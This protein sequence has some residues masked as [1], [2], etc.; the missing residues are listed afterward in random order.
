MQ[1]AFPLLCRSFM[2]S[3]NSWQKKSYSTSQVLL[4]S[5]NI[6]LQ[7][8]SYIKNEIFIFGWCPVFS[9]RK[10]QQKR[11]VSWEF[12]HNMC[13]SEWVNPGGHRGKSGEWEFMHT[14]SRVSWKLRRHLFEI[15]RQPSISSFYKARQPE[16][17]ATYSDFHLGKISGW[18]RVGRYQKQAHN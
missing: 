8:L 15:F 2:V 13:C 4:K 6:L 11:V 17:L 5:M 7:R 14:C 1:C 16:N 10:P 12:S 9:L 18:G 3:S